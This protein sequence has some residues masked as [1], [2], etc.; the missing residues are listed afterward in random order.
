VSRFPWRIALLYTAL[1]L[2]LAYP[3]SLDPAGRVLATAADTDLFMWTLAW[4]T[5]AFTHQPLSI[6][7]ANIYYP[8]ANTLA[9]SENLIG[10][11]LI[12]AP[13]LWMTGNPVLAMNVVALLSCVLCGVGAWLLARRI[14]VGPAGAAIAGVVF[15]FSPPRFLRLGQLHLTA[16]QW[17]PFALAFFHSYLDRGR[18]RDLRLAALFFTLQAL[19]SGHGAV[20]LALAL[21]GLI[22]YR[23]ALGEPIATL[24]RLRDLGATGLLLLAPAV[25]VVLPYLAV[26]REM[27]LRR[28]LR[29]SAE[30]ALPAVSFLASPA[31]VHQRVLSL[32]TDRDI[33][34]EAYAYLF[35]GYLP[36]VLAIAAIVLRDH[37]ATR[38]PRPWRD[39]WRR[40]GRTFYG[41]LTLAGVWIATGPPVGLW[42]AVY[43][44]PGLNFIRV[45]SRFSLL[46]MLGL[47]M[48]AGFGFDRLATRL[49]SHRRM[50]AGTLVCALLVLE[51]AVIPLDTAP[52]RVEIPAIDRWLDRQPKPF[53]V[54]EVPMPTSHEGGEERRQ[55]VYMLHATAH[56][57]KTVHGYSGLRP[58]LHA[59]LFRYLRVFPDEETI[60]R[61]KTL[62]VDYVVVHADLYP[63]GAWPEVEERLEQFAG[64]LRLEHIEG[65]GRVYAL[66]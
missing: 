3:L 24:R 28:S 12:A 41:L 7:D 21:A 17:M 61:L 54:A 56:W 29:D 9:Y 45:P 39:S 15:A 1:T 18:R 31:R 30:W 16:I 34:A 37:H 11:A 46:A 33:N 50:V 2:L 64:V 8:Q 49:S 47:A 32:A 58:P 42:P 25:L 4:D 27:G 52:Y 23:V 26:Q 65:S 48:L 63:A 14:G 53:V 13:V 59:E 6:F 60:G 19:S 43:W 51:F 66:Q 22:V 5:H 10:G 62:G 20:F 36:L 35:P 44:I 55:T 38:G 57:Q 40:D